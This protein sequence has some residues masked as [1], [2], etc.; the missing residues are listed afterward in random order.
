MTRY[1]RRARHLLPHGVV[2]HHTRYASFGN[3]CTAHLIS[4]MTR[5]RHNHRQTTVNAQCSRTPPWARKPQLLNLHT[6]LLV[7]S[8]LKLF[9]SLGTFKIAGLCTVLC[10]DITPL[11]TATVVFV[12][13]GLG[14]VVPF[15]FWSFLI[16]APGA[17]SA[18]VWRPRR[19]ID[20]PI[21]IHIRSDVIHALLQWRGTSGMSSVHDQETPPLCA[22]ESLRKTSRV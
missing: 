9:S 1:K 21:H 2:T 5:T 10:H 8:A 18:L 17:I 14:Y 22:R 6:F 7:T 11:R 4:V 12:F 20:R 3:R 19:S 16:R 15:F 13:L